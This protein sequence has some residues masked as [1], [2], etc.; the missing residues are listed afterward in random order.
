VFSRPYLFADLS[1]L[2][3]LFFLLN[4]QQQQ[5]EKANKRIKSF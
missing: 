2:S 3:F 4:K 1:Q 5:Q